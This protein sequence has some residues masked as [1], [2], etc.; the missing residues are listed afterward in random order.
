[1][2]SRLFDVTFLGIAVKCLSSYRIKLKWLRY[3]ILQLQH[4]G[5]EG[6]WSA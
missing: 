1:M 6:Q 3:E 5:L 4:V 2:Y